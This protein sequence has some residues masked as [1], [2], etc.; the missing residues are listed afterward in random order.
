MIDELF[1][2]CNGIGI[3]IWEVG[4]QAGN[5]KMK[6]SENNLWDFKTYKERWFAM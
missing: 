2:I 4:E 5:F 6:Q 1:L 3:C